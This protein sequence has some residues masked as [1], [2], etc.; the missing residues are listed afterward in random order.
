MHQNKN[1][2]VL[3]IVR[4][5]LPSAR[6]PPLLFILVS[7]QRPRS[8]GVRW[9]RGNV[10]R[11]GS[12]VVADEVSLLVD[13]RRQGED[14]VLFDVEERLGGA[15]LLGGLAVVVELRGEHRAVRAYRGELARAEDQ[16]LG[17]SR[18][19]DLAG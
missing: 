12:P 6:P 4:Y 14:R 3:R 19:L 7:Q 2:M 15:F 8:A 17:A 18:S 11:I 9:T 1:Q 10:D 5:R 13:H 16:N